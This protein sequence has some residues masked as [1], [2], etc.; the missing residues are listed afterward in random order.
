TEEHRIAEAAEAANQAKIEF[1]SRMS[2]ELRTPLNSI[3]GFSK[4]LK[5]SGL[6]ERD[7]QNANRV[8]IAGNHL[9]ALVDEILDI[10]RIESSE[11]HLNFESINIDELLSDVEGILKPIALQN[12]IGILRT[13]PEE[14]LLSVYSDRQRL[15]QIMLNLLSNAIKY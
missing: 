2:H 6:S 15:Q 11:L 1:L 10:S 7:T 12:E 8:H 3:I 9:L 13:K 14:S 5:M 4:L